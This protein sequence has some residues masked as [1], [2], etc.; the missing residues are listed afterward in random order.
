MAQ[1]TAEIMTGALANGKNRM[2][3]APKKILFLT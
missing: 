2:V 3:L 1:K